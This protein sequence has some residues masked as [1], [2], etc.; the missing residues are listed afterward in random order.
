MEG[1]ETTQLDLISPP[2]LSCV[3]ERA[4]FSQRHNPQ[5]L[6]TANQNDP[7]TGPCHAM[8]VLLSYEREVAVNSI[9]HGGT[10]MKWYGRSDVMSTHTRNDSLG[11][12]LVTS[13]PFWSRLS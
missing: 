8:T 12:F 7:K 11:H 5:C 9:Q 1:L 2:G 6:N 4:T 13:S 10:R 3:R